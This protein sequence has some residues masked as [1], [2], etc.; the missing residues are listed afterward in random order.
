MIDWK[1]DVDPAPETIAAYRGQVLSYL[2]ATG[3]GEGLIVFLTKGAA[4]RVQ[5]GS[6]PGP[7]VLRQIPLEEGKVRLGSLEPSLGTVGAYDDGAVVGEEVQ[8]DPATARRAPA[9]SPCG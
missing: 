8:R 6:G 3:A 1:S 7:D 2:R 4:E 5:V 9:A